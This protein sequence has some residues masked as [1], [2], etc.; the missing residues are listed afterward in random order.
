MEAGGLKPS[1]RCWH[2]SILGLLCESFWG[3]FANQVSRLFV[4]GLVIRDFHD[5]EYGIMSS[6]QYY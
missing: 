2:L 6:L 1:A 4:A 5:V 3:P